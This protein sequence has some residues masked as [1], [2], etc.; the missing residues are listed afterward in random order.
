MLNNI[1]ENK[2][3]KFMDDLKEN[4]LE[5]LQRLPEWEKYGDGWT[6]RTN[7]YCFGDTFSLFNK[8][9]IAEIKVSFSSSL[10]L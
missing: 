6:N 5:Y 8:S 10:G 4:R 1:P 7:T 9:F 2:V 3:D